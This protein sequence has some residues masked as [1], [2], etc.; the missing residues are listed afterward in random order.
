MILYK[1][2]IH[3]FTCGKKHKVVSI[4]Y[5]MGSY[6]ASQKILTSR[7]ETSYGS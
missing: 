2:T 5:E 7:K 3:F 1:S 6:N 4:N